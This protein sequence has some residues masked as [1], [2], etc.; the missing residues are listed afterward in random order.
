MFQSTTRKIQRWILW[1]GLLLLLS[2]IALVLPFRWI[3][4]PITAFMLQDWWISKQRPAQEW[5]ALHD[6]SPQ[7]RVAVIASEDQLF[8]VH[9]GFDLKMIADAM[10]EEPDKRRG[11]STISQQVAKNLYL[12][13]GRSYARKVIEA[14]LTLLIET[15]WP[16]ERIL[17]VYLNIAEFGRGIYGARTASQHLFG[18][19]P[20]RLNRYEAALLAAVLPNPKW[21]KA[22]QPSPYVRKRAVEIMLAIRDLG[23][24]T[25]LQQI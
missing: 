16:K 1:T 23:G 5:A 3:N 24:V 20:G 12:W 19:A 6:I 10:E 4:P 18:K 9:Y 13:N 25:Y 17:E 14:W 22:N 21:R 11:A 2:S 7:L 15:F 8:P